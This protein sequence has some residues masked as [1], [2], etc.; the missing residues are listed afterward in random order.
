MASRR[1]GDIP[2]DRLSDE[3]LRQAMVQLDQVIAIQQHRKSAEGHDLII[4][5]N[6]DEL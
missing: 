3:A 4:N 6:V 1:V 2:A 5:K